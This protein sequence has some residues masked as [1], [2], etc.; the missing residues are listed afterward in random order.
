MKALVIQETSLTPTVVLSI[1]RRMNSTRASRFWRFRFV[2]SKPRDARLSNR[3]GVGKSL[4]SESSSIGCVRLRRYA[5][6]PA[7][8]CSIDK[9]CGPV[10]TITGC[11]L[12][13]PCVARPTQVSG[14]SPQKAGCGE[15]GAMN[16]R[17]H[18]R[19][20]PPQGPLQGSLQGPLQ[21]PL[22]N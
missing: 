7:P 8:V 12:K 3:G 20:S 15:T 19:M 14:P 2:K 17:G 22:T 4:G 18:P 11:D 6:I 16:K 5:G 9:I 13:V 10:L 21:G 1:S